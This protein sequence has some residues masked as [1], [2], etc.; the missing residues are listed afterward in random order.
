M[1]ST[2]TLA[3]EKHEPRRL[4]LNLLPGFLLVTL[5]SIVFAAQEILGKSMHT[6]GILPRSP[7]GL[8]GI[9][10]SPFIHA[11]LEHLFSN[12]LP[13]IVLSW[14]LFTGYRKIALESFAWFWLLTGVWTWCLG[15][16]SYHIGASGVVYALMSF[17]FF[18]G[19]WRRDNRSMALTMLVITMYGGFIW[20]IVP[21]SN[22]HISWEAHLSGFL[23][24]L[25]LSW[26][27]RK[28]NAP[29]K[30]QWPE[31]H[32]ET[33]FW[34]G[35]DETS[36]HESPT[37]E[38]QED[39]ATNPAMQPSLDPLLSPFNAQPV[40]PRPVVIIRYVFVPNKPK[41]AASS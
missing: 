9:L 4:L 5:I 30:Y 24:G 33:E 20:G 15:R 34:L 16:P 27:F 8:L 38:T 35:N 36:L 22:S 21:L 26:H 25:V 37:E 11:D 13:L 29:A 2:Q 14:L 31:E 40:V 32:Y 10:T 7:K 1:T 39:S 19:L 6:A 23:A 3:Q 12:A 28:N 41:E 18:S 17:L